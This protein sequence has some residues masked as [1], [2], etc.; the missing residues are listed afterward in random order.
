MSRNEIGAAA[1]LTF[2]AG[3]NRARVIDPVHSGRPQSKTG[4]VI[5]SRREKAVPQGYGAFRR[6]VYRYDGAEL[7]LNETERGFA[8]GELKTITGSIGPG[9]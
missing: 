7:R 2:Y 5:T 6:I 1:R 9:S 8:F 4:F 3:V